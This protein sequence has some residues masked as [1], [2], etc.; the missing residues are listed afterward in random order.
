MTNRY[1]RWHGIAALV[2]SCSST[3]AWAQLPGTKLSP[4]NQLSRSWGF[5]VSDGYHE[6]VGC[7]HTNQRPN[8]ILRVNNCNLL[9]V[10]PEYR[11]K[12]SIG[13]MDPFKTILYDE[14]GGPNGCGVNTAQPMPMT[15]LPPSPQMYQQ[16]AAPQSTPLPG[17][18]FSQSDQGGTPSQAFPPSPPPSPWPAPNYK[19]SV[20]PD[21]IEDVESDRDSLLE[22]K[23]RDPKP[24]AVPPPPPLRKRQKDDKPLG[25]EPRANESLL[26]K[27]ETD[28][29]ESLDL[30]P[31]SDI[32]PVTVRQPRNP[33][34]SPFET[35]PVQVHASSYDVENA[36]MLQ[37]YYGNSY[38]QR[39]TTIELEAKR[40]G[41]NRYR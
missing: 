13:R 35:R 18:N 40:S 21:P 14:R 17:S 24:E 6:C 12:P 11:S 2:L 37:E 3:T 31:K 39:Q 27:K 22:Q 38:S 36:R 33:I 7:A 16:F 20:V 30:L 5:G 15:V 1:R 32:P 4:L 19:E 29:D 41:M 26:P 9:Y 28:Y 10:A 23:P 8:D 25:E 34:H